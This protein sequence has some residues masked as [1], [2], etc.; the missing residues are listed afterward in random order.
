MDQGIYI[1]F[2]IVL[3]PRS[4]FLVGKEGRHV[5][6]IGRATYTSINAAR[7]R[8][9]SV[10]LWFVD[11]VDPITVSVVQHRLIAIVEEMGEAM[12]RTSYSQILNS[13]R[14][15][16][17][18]ICDA[19]GR[20]LAQGVCTPMHLGSF[21]DAMR[22]IIRQYEGRI[23]EGDIFIANDPYAAEGQ[24]LPDIYIVKP[25]F[26]EG[27]LAGWSTTVAHHSDVGGIVP[28]SNALGAVEIYQEG[29]RLPVL[30]FVE[31]GKPN[32]AVWDIIALNVRTPEK[33]IGD[34]QAQMAACTSGER[35][36]QEVSKS[37][38]AAIT[39]HVS[40]CG[41]TITGRTI[42]RKGTLMS[43]WNKV[44]MLKAPCSRI[45][46]QN[47]LVSPSG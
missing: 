38:H 41:R 31:A 42:F 36:F 19:E 25:I 45:F 1:P 46:P 5:V 4:A 24:H 35:E 43:F 21:Y 11:N 14:D 28:G 29:L 13:S 17:T 16:S 27:R 20:T 22:Q 32:Q 26:W 44:A 18:A 10:E 40:V 23:E 37:L 47:I 30:K 2:G 15:F 34:L 7:G 33:V 9:L 8:R 6:R 3:V 12:L 39:H